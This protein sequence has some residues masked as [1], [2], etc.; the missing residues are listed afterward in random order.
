MPLKVLVTVFP[1]SVPPAPWKAKIWSP[2][3][4][5]NA[6]DEAVLPFELVTDVTVPILASMVPVAAAIVITVPA[7]I[8]VPVLFCHVTYCSWSL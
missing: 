6:I 8:V 7:T 4:L 2:E 1:G 3:L 5:T